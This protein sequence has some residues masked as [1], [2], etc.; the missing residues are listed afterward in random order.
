MRILATLF[1]LDYIIDY[2][3]YMC[4]HFFTSFEISKA[5]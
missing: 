5:K 4:Y 1:I 2:I 3:I